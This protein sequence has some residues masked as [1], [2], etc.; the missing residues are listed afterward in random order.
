LIG[1]KPHIEHQDFLDILNAIALSDSVKE[2]VEGCQG[3]V[4]YKYGMYH[5]IPTL[6]T[7]DFA[8]LNRFW[9]IGV[10]DEVLQYLENKKTQTDPVMKYVFS[11]GRPFW[12][13]GLLEQQD[14]TSEREHYRIKLALSNVGDGLVIPVFG[15]F[16]KQGYI[17]V[18]FE[19]AREFYSE[20][21]P[22]QIQ[23]IL[24]AV[25]T[26]YCNVVESFRTGVQ[27]TKR[28][29]EVLEL[30][31]F[32]KTNPEIG[33]ILGISPNTVSGYVKRIFL[34]FDV[35]DRVTVALRARASMFNEPNF[36]YMPKNI[37]RNTV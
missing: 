29:S 9:S 24:Q 14:F 1:L 36:H 17:V 34:K 26:R 10:S 27:L 5:H 32:G 15:P 19:N 25:H 31:T 35:T 21:F 18:G 7:R 6:G 12:M 8:N 2:L 20:V 37:H 16:H 4:S 3:R 28:E 13:S 33:M 23:A 22:W 11:K 30:I